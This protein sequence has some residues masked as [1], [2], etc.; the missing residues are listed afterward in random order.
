MCYEQVDMASVHFHEHLLDICNQAME[1]LEENHQSC[2]AKAKR[3][4][5]V[6]QEHYVV[7]LPL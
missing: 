4:E 6:N 1:V 2:Q 5:T 3:N 7:T